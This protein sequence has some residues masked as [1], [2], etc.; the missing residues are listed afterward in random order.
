MDLLFYKKFEPIYVIGHSNPD[1][2]SAISSKILCE[3]FNHYGIEAYYAVLDKDYEFKDGTYD[4]KMISECK[5]YKPVVIK[6]EDILKYNWF[7]VDH[8]DVV[9]SVGEDANVVAS[10][11]HHYNANSKN[12]YDFICTPL[13]AVALYLY[14]EFR[15]E[16]EF[17]DEQ[18]H[19]IYLAFLSDSVFGK[20]SKYS[21]YD[22]KLV[23]LLGY[24]TN[25]EEAFK[26]Y[27][28]PTD[29]SKG[30][31][32]CLHNG[33]KK[34]N[35]NGTKFESGYIEA[36]GTDGMDEYEKLVSKQK[37]FLGIWIDF[38]KEETHV[39]FQYNN[40]M[41]KMIYSFIASRGSTIIDDVLEYIYKLNKRR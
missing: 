5:D 29:L 23:E 26:K 25:Y 19:E 18:K 41:K 10:L 16:Y 33:Y 9:Q 21:I 28:I 3:L 37:S 7:L 32:A 22:E 11:D 15:K 20:S 6:S 39:F 27:F 36:F 14:N 31:D 17:S 40:K 13:S 35:F 30:I 12:V 34:Y 2:D 38:N 8:N 24:D 1:L 4:K